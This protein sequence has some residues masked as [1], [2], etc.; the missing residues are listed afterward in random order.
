MPVAGR[1]WNRFVCV[2]GAAR[3]VRLFV[4]RTHASHSFIHVCFLL[5]V[6][7]Q[8]VFVM[9]VRPCVAGGWPCHWSCGRSSSGDGRAV[10]LVAVAVLEGGLSAP[11]D[12]RAV[13]PAAG[14]ALGDGPSAHCGAN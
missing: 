10:G 13:V 5:Q 14:T 7:A 11:G 6:R 12:G 9:T 2:H 8:V 1:R 3:W 4:T